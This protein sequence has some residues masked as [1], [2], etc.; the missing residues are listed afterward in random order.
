MT[1]HLRG[2][3]RVERTDDEWRARLTEE[4]YRITRKKGTERAFTGV[5]NDTKTP[6]RYHC[7]CCGEPL[8][9]SDAKYDSGSGWPSFTRPADAKSIHLERDV[10][11]GMV[12][13]EVICAR[14]DAHLG[15]VFPDGPS[16]TGQ[17]FCINSA[18]L[19]LHPEEQ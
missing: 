17:R 4:Q 2:E 1:K 11:L 18:A 5:Y 7:V 15:H 3:D 16:D 10:S 6:G 9:S 19:E 14:C 8:F 12:R 13:T